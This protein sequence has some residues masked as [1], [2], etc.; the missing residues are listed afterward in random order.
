MSWD[1]EPWQQAD[2]L[3]QTD[4][5]IIDAYWQP[6]D[7][8]PVVVAEPEPVDVH[9]EW[10]EAEADDYPVVRESTEIEHYQPTQEDMQTA[11]EWLARVETMTQPQ[12]QLATHT[13]VQP[14]TLTALWQHVVSTLQTNTQRDTYSGHKSDY[15]SSASNRKPSWYFIAEPDP[16]EPQSLQHLRY[17]YMQSEFCE[18]VTEWSEARFMAWVASLSDAELATFADAGEQIAQGNWQDHVNDA[19]ADVIEQ[20]RES[21]QRER[22][23]VE[24]FFDSFKDLL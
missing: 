14:Q 7:D 2:D 8:S 5:G 17:W 12:S 23:P 10:L 11:N 6:V 19:T 9:V 16:D 22:G 21:Q 13:E 15:R 3:E 20:T 24:Y 4:D 18:G 1:L